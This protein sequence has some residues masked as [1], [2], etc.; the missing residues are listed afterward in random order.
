LGRQFGIDNDMEKSIGNE[1]CLVGSDV[2]IRI[3]SC[4]F[5]S[6]IVPLI[7]DFEKPIEGTIY[8]RDVIPLHDLIN[9]AKATTCVL[10]REHASAFIKD[11]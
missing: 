11:P 6:S 4:K 10:R 2:S 7:W 5:N 3:A 8:A 1:L 9:G